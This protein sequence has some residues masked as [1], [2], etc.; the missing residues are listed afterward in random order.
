MVPSSPKVPCRTGKTTSSEAAS[1]LQGCASSAL[2]PMCSEL[3]CA[4]RMRGGMCERFAA[5]QDGCGQGELE[6]RLR[7]RRCGRRRWQRG[8]GERIAAEQAIG[9]GAGE[10]AA[11]LVD[12]DGD[13]VVFL[14]VDG[15]EDGGGG[16]QGDFVL[17][18]AAAE[19]NAD[20]EFLLHGLLR[21]YGKFGRSRLDAQ[22]TA[23]VP[24][25]LKRP[26]RAKKWQENGHPGIA[27]AGMA[28]IIEQSQGAVP[29]AGKREGRLRCRARGPGEG[30]AALRLLLLFCAGCSQ[31]ESMA[32]ALGWCGLAAASLAMVLACGC[33]KHQQAAPLLRLR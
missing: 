7:R 22:G 31:E 15:F 32:V 10:P 14:A 25:R 19:E 1:G 17:A 9:V 33:D 3:G 28:S 13:D 11:L 8:P 5:A 26:L 30:N 6:R 24:G 20:A 23:G 2:A 29:E 27:G 21:E 16:E 12:A 18:G 4:R